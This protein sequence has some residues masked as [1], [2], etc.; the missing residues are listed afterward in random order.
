MDAR[1]LNND[2]LLATLMDISNEV[3][4]RESLSEYTDLIESCIKLSD[5]VLD[6]WILG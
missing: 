5:L 4:V 2:E 6:V 1:F 3:S